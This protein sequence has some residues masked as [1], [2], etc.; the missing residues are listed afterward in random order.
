MN[1]IFRDTMKKIQN[2]ILK[3]LKE[4]NSNKNSVRNATRILNFGVSQP[5]HNARTTANGACC[6]S[7]GLV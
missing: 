3:Y 2:Y 1:N 6:V 7:F 5:T 4:N